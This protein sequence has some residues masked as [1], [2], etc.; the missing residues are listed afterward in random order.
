MGS[1]SAKFCD[2]IFKHPGIFINL[3]SRDPRIPLRTDDNDN[4]NDDNECGYQATT[5][6]NSQSPYHQNQSATKESLKLNTLVE[7]MGFHF[8]VTNVISNVL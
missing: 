6:N 5:K 2:F 3:K 7:H 1:A 4:D 8:R